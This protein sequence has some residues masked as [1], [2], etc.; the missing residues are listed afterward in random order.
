VIVDG[1]RLPSCFALAA[2]CGGRQAV[3]IEGLAAGE[4]LDPMQA[5]VYVERAVHKQST[6]MAPAV[7][8]SQ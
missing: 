1:E 7:R 3:M 4:E 5:A 8:E 2:V 6:G